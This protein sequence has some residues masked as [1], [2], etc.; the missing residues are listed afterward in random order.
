MRG[1]VIASQDCCLP[2]S[3]P[4]CCDR[5]RIRREAVFN[6][7]RPAK[8]V[9]IICNQHIRKADLLLFGQD[10]IRRLICIHHVCLSVV[11]VGSFNSLSD[12]LADAN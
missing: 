6:L 10:R 5:N 2:I 3:H 12:D 4:D 9:V 11:T 7:H 8:R 1:N